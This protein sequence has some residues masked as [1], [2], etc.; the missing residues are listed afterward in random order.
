MSEKD[1]EV[2]VKAGATTIEPDTEDVILKPSEKD[3]INHKKVD[4]EFL[5]D[6]PLEISIELGR[7][8]VVLQD[9]LRLGQGSVLQ[10]NKA[11]GESVDVLANRRP[12]AK[13]E[14]VEIN[15]HYGI[16]ITEIKTPEER[17]EK[18]K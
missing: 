2:G 10:L 13:A 1:F 16:R 11:V 5:L 3:S 15:D 17:I 4:I 18:L 7:I 12:I 14:V 9:L 6:I 8:N